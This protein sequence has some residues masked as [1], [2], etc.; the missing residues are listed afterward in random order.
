MEETENAISHAQAKAILKVA[1]LLAAVDG[2]ISSGEK[3]LFRTLMRKLFG[4]RYL[5]G[6]VLSYLEE[7]AED[8]RKLVQLRDF[9]S[10]E[11][12]IVKAFAGKAATAVSELLCSRYA[13]RSAFAVWIS[14]CC[15]DGDYSAIERKAVSTLLGSINPAAFKK[16]LV[17]GGIAAAASIVAG[18]VVALPIVG[19]MGLKLAF[20]RSITPAFL[21]DVEKRVVR[22]REY[23]R[24]AEESAD[25]AAKANYMG[26]YEAE[27]EELVEFLRGE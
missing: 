11:D 5:D 24:R 6:D 9:Y 18:P 2:N 22:I 7:V 25:S 19:F 4:D 3:A 10:E 16:G 26:M 23:N 17:A 20:S 13:L 15:A 21:K 27:I 1:Y 14:M 8:A 12:E